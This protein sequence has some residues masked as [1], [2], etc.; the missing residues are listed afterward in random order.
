MD[1]M[2]LGGLVLPLYR[3]LSVVLWFACFV[4]LS[5]SWPSLWVRQV[6]YSL[7]IALDGRNSLN[8]YHQ[9]FAVRVVE[10]EMAECLRKVTLASCI[11][12]PH[13]GS[14]IKQQPQP[15]AGK[16]QWCL[17]SSLLTEPPLLLNLTKT[18]SICISPMNTPL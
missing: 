14:P 10:G 6:Q 3:K 13:T 15:Q 7:A 2:M 16:A 11:V 5:L 18:P 12:P 4:C 8:V 17:W 1:E 9:E